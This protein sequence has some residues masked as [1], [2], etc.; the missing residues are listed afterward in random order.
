MRLIGMLVGIGILALFALMVFTSVLA[1]MQPVASLPVSTGGIGGSTTLPPGL[2]LT[3]P[4][5][6]L[7]WDDAVQVGIP[8]ATLCD[9]SIRRAV[10]SPMPCLRLARKGLLSSCLPLLPRLVSIPGIL[11]RRWRG[12]QA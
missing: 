11:S 2:S 3:M 8:P 4:Y 5:V 6:R 12:P 9:K 1:S 10:F 7:A